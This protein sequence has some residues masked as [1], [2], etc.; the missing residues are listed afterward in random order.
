MPGKSTIALALKMASKLVWIK[1]TISITVQTETLLIAP[2]AVS[3]PLHHLLLHSLKCTLKSSS[4]NQTLTCKPNQSPLQQL[5][6]SL[7]PLPLPTSKSSAILSWVALPPTPVQTRET[8]RLPTSL[9]LDGFSQR[10]SEQYTRILH[11]IENLTPD[12]PQ[13]NR[14]KLVPQ[15]VYISQHAS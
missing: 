14:G 8:L 13:D 7:R 5:T 6:P 9:S 15:F 11:T 4:P 12:T 10:S 1:P 2:T 3:M